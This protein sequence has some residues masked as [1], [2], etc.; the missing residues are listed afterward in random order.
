MDLDLLGMGG[1]SSFRS[2]WH[3]ICEQARLVEDL[4]FSA[5]WGSDHLWNLRDNFLPAQERFTVIAA[6]AMERKRLKFGTAVVGNTYR[7]P[8]IL[9]KL[10]ATADVISDGRLILGVGSGWT[11][12]EHRA[13]GIPFPSFRERAEALDEALSIIRGLWTEQRL[14]FSGKHYSIDDAPF[15]PKCV[16]KP[17]VPLVI[18]GNSSALLRIVAIHAD[19]WNIGLGSPGFIRDKSAVLE[20]ICEEIGRDPKSIRRSTIVNVRLL[21]RADEI[22]STRLQYLAVEKERAARGQGQRVKWIGKNE[23]LDEAMLA[24]TLIGTPAYVIDGIGRLRDL[25]MHRV[26]LS[27]EPPDE[28]RRFAGEVMPA[29][30]GP[31]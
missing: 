9:A 13:Y 10:A 12:P 24:M 5:L 21:D 16:Q 14:S 2:T 20:R 30:A 22:R 15:E 7:H 11:E 19:E 8:V 4:G 18:G 26:I 31:A 17:H 1:A 23:E 25:G 28:I 27:M 3:D 29:F 6:L